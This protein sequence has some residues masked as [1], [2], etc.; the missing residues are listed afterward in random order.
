MIGRDLVGAPKLVVD[1]DDFRQDSEGCG[2][3]VSDNGFCFLEGKLQ[4]LDCK[5]TAGPNCADEIVSQI[6]HAVPHA[7][8]TA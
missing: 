1:I 6:A 2:W 8:V 5:T 7:P 4:R 3:R